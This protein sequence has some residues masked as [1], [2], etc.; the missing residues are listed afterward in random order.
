[1]ASGGN[2]TRDSS[3]LGPAKIAA[4]AVLVA[5]ISAGVTFSLMRSPVRV[6]RE[7]GVVYV[8]PPQGEKARTEAAD[9][10]VV[11]AVPTVRDAGE[12][13]TKVEP[14]AAAAPDEPPREEE[15][16][17][18]TAPMGKINLNTATQAELE[19]L[20]DIGPK[21]AAAILDYRK[22]KGPFKSVADLDKVKG[23]GERTLK[24]IA[25]LVTVD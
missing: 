11:E 17:T 20:P 16:A 7:P 1:M 14:L 10:A 4:V 23:I 22:S 19:L 8:L 25:P 6:I 24:K 12:V 13:L 2:Q 9:P 3:T 21:T 18:P 5:A 15:P